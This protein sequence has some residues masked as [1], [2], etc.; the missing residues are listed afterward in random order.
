MDRTARGLGVIDWQRAWRDRFGARWHY[1]YGGWVRTRRGAEA[2]ES[3]G[4]AKRTVPAIRA[5]V[6]RM[7]PIRKHFMV[8]VF[9]LTAMHLMGNKRPPGQKLVQAK[10]AKNGVPLGKSYDQHDPHV[11]LRML[12]ESNITGGFKKGW[13][14]FDES[15]GKAGESFAIELREVRNTSA[16][17]GSFSDDDAYGH[18]TPLVDD[19]V[20]VSTTA[21]LLVY[22]SGTGTARWVPGRR[23]R[24][25]RGRKA[26]RRRKKRQSC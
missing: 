15:L 5:G 11:Q 6:R 8:Q 25:L 2:S 10:D 12:T 17:N 19:M 18:W 1:A 9:P 3:G 13:Y 20:F 23:G 22:C 16:H 24:R 26:A 14:P 4:Y 21:F 7:R